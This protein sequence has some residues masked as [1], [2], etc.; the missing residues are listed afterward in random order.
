MSK[1]LIAVSIVRLVVGVDGHLEARGAV[2]DNDNKLL[3]DQSSGRLNC[4]A[5]TT[6]LSVHPS[7]ATDK[8]GKSK[9]LH[10]STFF[11]AQVAVRAS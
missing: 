10:F 4:E 1:G 11:P 6:L 5:D 2:L 8:E 7:F 9:K 3:I